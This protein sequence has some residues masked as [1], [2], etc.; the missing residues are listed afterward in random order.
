[1]NEKGVFGY[2]FA[3]AIAVIF[4]LVIFG[5]LA[6]VLSNFSSSIY[7][8]LQPL[9]NATLANA[10]QIQD[11]NISAA[12]TDSV[13]TANGFQSDNIQLFQLLYGFAAIITIVIVGIVYWLLTQKQVE[14][15]RSYGGGGIQ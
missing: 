3:F 14:A 7:V 6:I 9:Q 13:N 2:A 12:I 1:M 11:A 8:G 15:N 5:V 10:A 4:C